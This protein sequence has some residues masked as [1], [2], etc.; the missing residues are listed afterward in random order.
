MTEDTMGATDHRSNCTCGS[1]EGIF[2]GKRINSKR[3]RLVSSI[4]AVFAAGMG[5]SLQNSANAQ[6]RSA[7]ESK[8]TSKDQS[9]P[10]GVRRI[11]VH[12]HYL[13]ERYRQEAIAAGHQKPDGMPGLPKWSIE[14]ALTAMDKFGIS[15]SI[16]SVSSPGVHFGQDLAAIKLAR[17]V[18]E[19]G[20]HAVQT[21]PQRFGLFAS[22][23]LPNVDAA[24]K[25][26]EYALDVLKADGIVMESN[27]HGVYPGDPRLDPVMEELNRRKA[28]LFLH[29]TSP[30]CPCCQETSLGY[31]RPMM[32]FMFETSR[33]VTNMILKG[34]LE[35]Y[36]DIRLIIPHAGA[37]IPILVDRITGLSPALGLDAPLNTERVFS[38]LK[39]LHY[40]LAGFPIPRQLGALLQIA[41]EKHIMY[42]SDWPFTPDPVVA[43]LSKKI[44]ETDL[45]TD[46]QR[47]QI[48]GRN[49]LKLFPRLDS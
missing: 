30:D 41:D 24:L 29:P 31:P 47:I 5:V 12:S 28:V 42:G 49:A 2:T 10:I 16:L 35:K 21:H 8:S 6:S 19:V 23:P 32:E 9:D 36:P 13:P 3:R 44:D 43:I 37:M 34:T 27:H 22:L 14:T 48:L 26:I 33:A 11:D 46:E 38:L 1:C 39:R 18:N 7:S 4:P 15:T 40:D 45:L 25:E 17:A 20:A